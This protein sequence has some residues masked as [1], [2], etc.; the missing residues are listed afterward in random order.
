MIIYNKPEGELCT[1]DDPQGRPTI[2]KNL[3]PLKQGRWINVGRLDINSSGLILL[4][5]DG[6]LANKLMHP[7]HEVE[8]E[9]AVRV[10]GLITPEIIEN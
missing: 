8:R 2:F 6:A 10:F 3:P 4:T 5:N 7:R 9:Y 1:R